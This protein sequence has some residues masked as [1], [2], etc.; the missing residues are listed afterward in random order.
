MTA[1]RFHTQIHKI[2]T[3][4][5]KSDFCNEKLY[6]PPIFLDVTMKERSKSLSLT[7]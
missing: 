7:T 3:E 4:I 1:H 5:Y 6:E 2:D